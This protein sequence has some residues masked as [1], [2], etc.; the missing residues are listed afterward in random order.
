MSETFDWIV[1]GGGF[2]SVVGAYALA[3]SGQRVCLVEAAPKIGGFLSPIPWEGFWVDKGPQ[4]FDNFNQS[5]RELIEEMVGPGLLQDIGFSY[6]S[7][8]KGVLTEEFAIPDWRSFGDEFVQNAFFDLLKIAGQDKEQLEPPMNFAEVLD[9]DGGASVGL[10]QKKF[11]EKILG[12]PA[13]SLGASAANLVTFTGRKLLFDD[14]ISRQLK[15]SELL[16]KFIAA[17]KVTV[18]EPVFNL[19]P[20]GRNL[21]AVRVALEE[22][23]QRIGV[24]V[25]TEVKITSFTRDGSEAVLS[26][27]AKV[28][29]NSILFGGHIIDAEKTIYGAGEIT[30]SIIEL[31]EVFH[32]FLIPT[33]NVHSS[34]YVMDYDLAHKTT[35]VTNFCNYMGCIDEEGFGVICA[36]QPIARDSAQWENPQIDQKTIFNEMQQAGLASG[37]VKKSI[38]IKVPSTYKLPKQGYASAVSSFRQRVLNDYGASFVIPDAFGLTRKS[39]LDS[40]RE[41]KIL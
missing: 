6:S 13:E 24:S 12:H 34:Y 40:L 5:D 32:F 22:S 38:S 26:N 9:M 8:T 28:G 30:Q 4:F 1:V 31:P 36:E 35:R 41:L 20:R 19:Y 39:G 25:K 15:Q 2:R 23:L 18:G 16:D 7:Y 10:M 33:Q 11:C 3:R 29:F 14:E 37:P 21:D 27:G 17:Q